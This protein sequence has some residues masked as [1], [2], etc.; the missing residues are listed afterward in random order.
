M[1]KQLIILISA[2]FL[3]L[4][5]CKTDKDSI[6]LFPIKSGDKWG[7][8]DKN[9]QYIINS[10]FEEAYNFS[11]GLALFRSTDGKYGFI[12]EEGK[13][14]INPIYK[15]ANSFSEGMSCVVM[16]NGK[17]VESG[18]SDSVFAN[19]QHPYTQKLIRAIPTTE[20]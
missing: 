6:K 18:D 16:E 12:D 19:P 2:A 8:V 11:E 15:D 10:Q 1:K 9:G 20:F 13:Y 4:G 17:I 7:Y 3:I 5:S 14:V